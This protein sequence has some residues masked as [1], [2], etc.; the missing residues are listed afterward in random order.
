MPPDTCTTLTEMP[1][2]E[3][4]Q[5]VDAENLVRQLL[6]RA[7]ALLR[8][9]A[10]VRGDAADAQLIVAAAFARGL[11][12][13]AGQR[14]LEHQHRALR[15]ASSSIAARDVSLP[16]S[17][18]V[19]QSMTMRWLSGDAGLEERAGGQ[20]RDGDAG[21][22]VEDAGAVQ[23]PARSGQRHPV[24]L[25]DRPH[26]VEVAEQQDLRCAAAEFRE[27]VIAAVRARQPA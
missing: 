26:G 27:Q 24:E 14:R 19:V 18:S 7:R 25:A 16:T 10:G 20:H 21:L 1:A 6:N 9:D 15:R 23:A 2:I 17:S 11:H 13:A 12:R 4:L 3:I 5:R 22:H 8:L